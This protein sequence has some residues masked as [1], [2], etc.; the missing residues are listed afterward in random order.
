M[1]VVAKWVLLIA[2]IAA[3]LL[4]E[5]GVQHTPPTHV[6]FSP[7]LSTCGLV[8]PL[9]AC[10]RGWF[11]SAGRPRLAAGRSAGLFSSLCIAC[12]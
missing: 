2:R 9:V 10:R 4:L 12:R 8:S 6:P 7:L 5:A 3:P 1:S 11:E